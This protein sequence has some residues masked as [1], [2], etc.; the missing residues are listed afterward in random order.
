MNLPTMARWKEL[1]ALI[2]NVPCG[3]EVEVFEPRTIEDINSASTGW[4]FEGVGDY[5]YTIRVS[6]EHQKTFVRMLELSDEFVL[7]IGFNKGYSG[8]SY[9][10]GLYDIMV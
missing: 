10:F 5:S 9:V 4:L 1:C 6:A 2:E 3:L 8:I 7:E